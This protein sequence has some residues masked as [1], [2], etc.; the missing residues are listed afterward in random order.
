MAGCLPEVI[1]FAEAR[2]QKYVP[3]EIFVMDVCQSADQYYIL[4]CGCLNAAG[5]YEADVYAIVRA[6]TAHI[7]GI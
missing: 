3:H 7:Y 4:E 5:F 2:C 6:V 1:S